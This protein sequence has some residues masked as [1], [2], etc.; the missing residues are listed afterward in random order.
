MYIVKFY[1]PG[2]LRAISMVNDSTEDH[3]FKSL[4]MHVLSKNFADQIT[5]QVVDEQKQEVFGKTFSYVD[6][7]LGKIEGTGEIVTTEEFAGERNFCKYVN[8]YGAIAVGNDPEL[9]E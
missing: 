7:F 3:A 2:T 4:Q 6:V 8:N 1:H 9:E 5:V